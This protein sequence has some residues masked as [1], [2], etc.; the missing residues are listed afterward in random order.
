[1]GTIG[2]LGAESTKNKILELSKDNPKLLEQYNNFIRIAN[3]SKEDISKLDAN[4]EL[5]INE[6]TSEDVDE[7]VPK[8]FPQKLSL[9]DWDKHT[10]YENK[11]ELIDG[12][13]LWGDVF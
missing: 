7:L 5:N 6:N 9:D 2:K 1:M 10:P 12:E 8:R 11:L 4:I 13:V 3:M